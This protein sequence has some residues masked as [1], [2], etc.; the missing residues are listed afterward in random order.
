MTNKIRIKP[1]TGALGA[2]ILGI[3]L[4]KTLSKKHFNLI[5]NTLNEYHVIFFRKQDIS[6]VQLVTFGKNFG[7]L[8]IHPLIP[9]LKDFPEIIELKSADDGPGPYSRNSRIW[10]SDM[11]YTKIPPMGAILKAI[12]I[13]ESGGNT[14]FLNACLAYEQLSKK[15]KNFLSKLQAVHS[16]VMTNTKEEILSE[17][18]L[19]RFAKM[20]K[21][22]PPVEHPVIKIHPETGKK[23]IYVNEAF[24]SHITG[25]NHNE[26]DSLLDFLYKHLHN[27]DFQCRFIWEKNSIA[28]W[29]N[30]V[31]QHF[32]VGDYNTKRIMHRLTIKGTKLN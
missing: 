4:S 14:M 17:Q 8:E 28:F 11:T 15:M 22:L 30:Q 32:A 29:D 9:T 21:A 27:P 31:T 13:P 16:I 19:S 25:L 26:S 2:E 18:G 1:Y 3:D 7:K 23:C 24:T 5:K 12:T 6:P 10:H 20:Q